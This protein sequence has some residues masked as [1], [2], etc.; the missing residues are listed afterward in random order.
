[1]TSYV[2]HN[3]VKYWQLIN[4]IPNGVAPLCSCSSGHVHTIYAIA[5]DSVDRLS[6]I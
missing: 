3:L 5:Y 2:G 1:M 6:R 4:N